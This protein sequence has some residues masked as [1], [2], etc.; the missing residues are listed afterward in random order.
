MARY[1]LVA[2]NTSTPQLEAAQSGDTYLIPRTAEMETGAEHRLY[3]TADMDTNFERGFL[4][5]ESNQLR[6]GTEKGGTG[7]VRDIWFYHGTGYRL[8]VGDGF[9]ETRGQIKPSA[10]NTYTIGDSSTSYA[11]LYMS[12]RSADPTVNVEGTCC[13]WQSNGTG[14]GDDGDIMITIRAGGVNKT[15]TL[16]DYSAIA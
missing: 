2:L 11:G 8:R 4:R 14:S 6:I 16:V 3:N 10:N 7:T 5:W 1:E 15:A 9:V 12:E 13:I